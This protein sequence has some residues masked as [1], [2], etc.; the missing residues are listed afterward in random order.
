MYKLPEAGYLRL[1]Q[2]SFNQRKNH[3]TVQ[4][5]KRRL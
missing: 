2:I 4:S 1:P 3:A 5:Y